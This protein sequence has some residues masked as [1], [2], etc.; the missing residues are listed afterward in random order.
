LRF[1]LDTNACIELLRPTGS[2][3]LRQ[4]LQECEPGDVC[5]CS[6]VR[7]ELVFG[8]LRSQ[9]VAENLGHVN[10]LLSGLPSLAI[11]DR[12]A[13]R[14]AQVH[15]HLTAAG[16]TVGPNDLLIAASALAHGLTLVTHNT[17]EFAR[18]PGLSTADWEAT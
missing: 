2:K 16:T 14:A 4:Q 9:R 18:V 6:I 3:L 13:D 10:R 7:M 11:D 12:V 1:L 5:V 17:V 8:A 15:A